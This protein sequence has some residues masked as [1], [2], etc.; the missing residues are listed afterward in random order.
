MH[1][2]AVLLAAPRENLDETG[3]HGEGGTHIGRRVRLLNAVILFATTLGQRGFEC[4]PVCSRG[5]CVATPQWYQP[6]VQRVGDVGPYLALVAT[7]VIVFVRVGAERNGRL[8][9][10]TSWMDVEE[11]CRL[12]AAAETRANGAFP[13]WEPNLAQISMTAARIFHARAVERRPKIIRSSPGPTC[14]GKKAGIHVLSCIALHAPAH[15]TDNY[16]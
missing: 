10:L 16:I 6:L 9:V 5:L 11:D 2:N 13:G 7:S 8:R 12:R 14:R 15:E 3:R 4:Q 1:V